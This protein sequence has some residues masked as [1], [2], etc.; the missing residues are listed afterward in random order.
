MFWGQWEKFGSG[1]GIRYQSQ[2]D[3]DIPGMWENVLI[4]RR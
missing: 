2:T 3:N 1:L 4:F